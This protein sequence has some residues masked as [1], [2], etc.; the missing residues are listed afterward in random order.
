MV[1]CKF[2]GVKPC[3]YHYCLVG[4][5]EVT[6]LASF[7]SLLMLVTSFPVTISYLFVSIGWLLV[8][9]VTVEVILCPTPSL[10]T[11]PLLVLIGAPVVKVLKVVGGLVTLVPT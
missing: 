3:H 10:F 5:I 9:L 1:V 8:I 2:D 4:R 6:C 11:S 7:R